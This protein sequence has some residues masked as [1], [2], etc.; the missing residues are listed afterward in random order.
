MLRECTDICSIGDNV[1]AGHQSPSFDGRGE[2]LN[3]RGVL[4]CGHIKC[5]GL[6]QSD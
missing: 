2:M 5:G 3:S 6:H 4:D 1:N